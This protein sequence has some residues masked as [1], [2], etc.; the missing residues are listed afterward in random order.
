VE[1]AR[2]T[3]VTSSVNGLSSK[4]TILSAVLGLVGVQVLLGLSG[5]VHQ[6]LTFVLFRHGAGI[7]RKFCGIWS[8]FQGMVV[9]FRDLSQ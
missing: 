1:R 2:H 8:G 3:A 4:A 5:D 6:V 9:C 7:D